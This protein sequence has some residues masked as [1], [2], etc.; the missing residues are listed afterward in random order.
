M[1]AP[2]EKPGPR[3]PAVAELAGQ[4]NNHL[5]VLDLTVAQRDRPRT[6]VAAEGFSMGASI[7]LRYAGLV[8]GLTPVVSVSGPA[9]GTTA[10]HSRCGGSTARRTPGRPVR[11][12]PVLKT[13]ISPEGWK[14]VPVPPAEAAARISPVPLLIV[15][16]EKDHYFP[17]EHARQLYMAPGSPRSSG[18]YR[19]WATPSPPAARNWSTAS[20]TGSARPRRRPVRR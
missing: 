7:V 14:L 2:I 15:H 3:R 9:A 20:A 10:A 8:G 6:A 1:E 17:S 18:S 13:R 5:E 16:G 12:P 19:T 4:R 11:H